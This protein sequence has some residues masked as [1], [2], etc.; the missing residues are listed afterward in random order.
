M[1]NRDKNIIKKSKF[2]RFNSTNW[3]IIIIALYLVII[4]VV[5]IRQ[6]HINPYL[7]E[8]YTYHDDSIVQGIALFDEKV[9]KSDASGYID[10]YVPEGDRVKVGA[11]VYT[12]DETGEFSKLLSKT[13]EGQTQ[14]FNSDQ[15]YDLKDK[16][17]AISTGYSDTK[18]S[19]LYSSKKK[20]D[21]S[22]LDYLYDSAVSEL[23]SSL[24]TSGYVQCKSDK[25]TICLFHIDGYEG[26]APASL[27]SEDFSG[28]NYQSKVL[29]TGEM[30]VSGTDVYK[31]INSDKWQI[32]FE[33]TE[34]ISS[35]INLGVNTLE[36]YFP[37]TDMTMELPFS[38]AVSTKDGS[39]IGI[40]SMNKYLNNYLEDRFVDFQI[41]TNDING[42]LIP[43]KSVTTNTYYSVP[44]NFG[45]YGQD[46]TL[47]FYVVHPQTGDLTPKFENLTF[48]GVSGGNYL[49]SNKEVAVGDYLIMPFEI[50]SEDAP[51]D[52]NPMI[53]FEKQ[54]RFY[55]GPMETLSGVYNINQG[56]T[57]FRKV[58]PIGE[59]D[60]MY[61]VSPSTRYGISEYDHIAISA[62]GIEE[63]KLVK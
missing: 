4:L 31:E 23:N 12:L 28:K 13:L 50:G 33:I 56:Y 22:V 20:L 49:I 26:V 52:G 32:C 45:C 35:K 2:H 15:W 41:V 51:E 43:K 7:V 9:Q 63:F 24:D 19:D 10:F 58:V 29:R 38:V 60:D 11:T 17:F 44:A 8:S 36:V 5:Y 6:D 3:V 48:Y 1:A 54:E 42:L 16:L 34:A 39:K 14:T 18:F 59:V 27:G 53:D 21:S 46:G 61:I 30:V 57:F 47:G 40:L 25:S 55:I 37:K 62:E